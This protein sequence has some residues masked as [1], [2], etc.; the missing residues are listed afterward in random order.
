MDIKGLDDWM[1]LPN[2][3]NSIP[4]AR[5]SS[6]PRNERCL[7]PGF[8]AF[9][10]FEA[11]VGSICNVGRQVPILLLKALTVMSKWWKA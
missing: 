4:K 6:Q 10:S 5:C 9:D 11:F 3:D 8:C 2:V 7:N 1:P